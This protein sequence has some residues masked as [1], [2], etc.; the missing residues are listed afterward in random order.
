MPPSRVK[1]DPLNLGRIGSSETSVTINPRCV[2]IPQKRRSY[3]HTDGTLKSLIAIEF[4][5]ITLSFDQCRQ[6]GVTLEWHRGQ[7]SAPWQ[8]SRKVNWCQY[9]WRHMSQK[10]IFHSHLCEHLSNHLQ[11]TLPHSH[12]I[13]LKCPW[14]H[15]TLILGCV[16]YRYSSN[17]VETE[18][19]HR[20]N[21]LGISCARFIFLLGNATAWAVIRTE[22]HLLTL[23]LKKRRKKK[24]D[25]F[26][27]DLPSGTTT[28]AFAPIHYHYCFPRRTEWQADGLWITDWLATHL[29]YHVSDTCYARTTPRPLSLGISLFL[30][31]PSS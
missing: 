27:L 28:F 2:N 23:S 19:V 20:S 14:M 24:Q 3:L 9:T 15:R 8:H 6:L 12:I 21:V 13:Q 29:L 10:G 31:Q 16:L 26:S 4:Q 30:H 22:P 18:C 7:G 11:A 5:F 25:T 1:Q 17:C